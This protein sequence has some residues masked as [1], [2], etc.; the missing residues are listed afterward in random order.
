[1][2]K[3][4]LCL[5]LC[6]VMML[7]VMLAGCSTDTEDTSPSDGTTTVNRNAMTVTIAMSKG[8]GTT[9]EAAQKV[10][11]AINV[12]TESK[13]NTHVELY[14]YEK[15]ELKDAIVNKVNEIGNLLE[16]GENLA[17]EEVDEEKEDIVI[18]DEESGRK[19]T[20]YPEVANT[21]FDIILINGID[22]YNEYLNMDVFIDGE[23]EK[24]LLTPIVPSNLI[25]QYVN[26]TLLSTAQ[27]A[28]L[29][30]LGTG[31]IYAVPNNRDFGEYTYLVINK[32]LCDSL[33]YNPDELT[34]R[35][36]EGTATGFVSSLYS[37][38]DFLTSVHNSNPNMTLMANV[39]NID[40]IF[41]TIDSGLPVGR[42]QFMAAGAKT[43]TLLEAPPNNL[44]G[45]DAYK[46]FY[47][48]MLQLKEWGQMPTAETADLTSDF[49]V[50]YVKG[51]ATTIENIDPDKYYVR[52]CDAPVK[53]NEYV[54]SSMYAVTKYSI[55]AERAGA[56]IELFNTNAQFRNLMYY[57]VENVHYTVEENGDYTKIS[58]DWNMDIYDTGNLYLL[59][60]SES[61]GDYYYSMSA[62]KWEA[63]KA[64]NRDAVDGL[65]L[66]FYYRSDAAMDSA[67]ESLRTKT[68]QW[69]QDILAGSMTTAQVKDAIDFDPSFELL[70]DSDNA[71][72][73]YSQYRAWY[74]TMVPSKG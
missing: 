34:S 39:P 25:R 55:N 36:M 45:S 19:Q 15:D 1:M 71:D 46:N 57:G 40:T 51:N 16:N 8:E 61:L 6:L 28:M 7:G 30:D 3:R 10:E 2:K 21:Q 54:Y 5:G 9:D 67:I 11:D 44:Y 53:S 52:V 17:A 14:L 74:N 50:A 13:L 69:H 35:E 22:E 58:N 32:A 42:S 23:P 33:G 24:N 56:V 62:N 70:V 29:K 49:A 65:L 73:I 4:F 18:V 41:Y 66:G 26:A 47:S 43:S 64:L 37:V 38:S 72:S 59:E 31:G 68:A 27:D 20:Q 60:R 12:I 48:V 63:G